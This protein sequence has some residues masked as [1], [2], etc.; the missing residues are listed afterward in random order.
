M[1]RAKSMSPP[2]FHAMTWIFLCLVFIGFAPSFFLKFWIEAQPFYPEG[3]P[4]PYILHGLVLTVWY[5]FLVVQSTLIK[6]RSLNLH[7]KIGYFGAIWAFFVLASTLWVISLFPSRMEELSFALGKTVQEI[8]PGLSGILW[9]DFFMSLLF[10]SFVG[11]GIAERKNPEAHKRL[12]FFSGL[13]FLFAAVFRISGIVGTLGGIEAGP[14]FGLGL[15]LVISISVL[16]YDRMQLGKV[17]PITWG[18]FGF[19][20]FG[21]ILSFILGESSWGKE[22][23][24]GLF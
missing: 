11:L 7:R 13:V 22:F 15:L 5:V 18:C 3:L 2:Y 16:F 10:S 23:M 4:I 8:E 17:L 14:V 24:L 9:L 1:K 20:W 6:N 12:M 19:Y 21:V